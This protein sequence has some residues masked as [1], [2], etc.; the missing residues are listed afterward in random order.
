[1]ADVAGVVAAQEARLDE[2]DLRLGRRDAEPCTPE[3]RAPF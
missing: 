2:A 1:V 3:A